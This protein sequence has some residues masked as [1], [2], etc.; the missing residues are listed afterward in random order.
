MES[1][2]APALN[3]LSDLFCNPN[4][5]EILLTNFFFRV[6]NVDSLFDVKVP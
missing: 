6:R 5:M 2:P 1:K 4:V 3:I